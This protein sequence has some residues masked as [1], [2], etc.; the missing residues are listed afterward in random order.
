MK[1]IVT[2]H[3]HPVYK[4]L[5]RT[6]KY[7]NLGPVYQF[8]NYHEKLHYLFRSSSFHVQ[9][10]NTSFSK[11]NIYVL[12]SPLI[13]LEAWIAAKNRI[14]SIFVEEYF[15]KSKYKDTLV[16]FI[17]KLF[18]NYP[19]IAMTKRTHTFLLESRLSS[20]LIPPAL[21][22]KK[23]RKTRDI[24]LFIGRMIDTKNPFFV[25]EIAKRLKKRRF[26]DDRKGP[27]ITT[28]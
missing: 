13:G 17:L 8:K 15:H 7:M 27:A 12:N 22:K 2:L 25:F 14:N 24:I 3:N 28:S 16:K 26:C 10:L 23:G 21:E 20:F 18:Q 9:Y 1:V 5:F 4:S 6:F 19:F 11:E